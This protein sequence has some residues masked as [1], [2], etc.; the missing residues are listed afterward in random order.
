MGKGFFDAPVSGGGGFFTGGTDQGFFGGPG[1]GA[2]S[3]PKKKSWKDFGKDIG[4][5]GSPLGYFLEQS[6]ILPGPGRVIQALGS[7]PIEAVAHP[8]ALTKGAWQSV[9]GTVESPY[10]IY[11]LHHTGM[12][13]GDVGDAVIK[14]FVSDY[15]RRYGKN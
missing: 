11:Q 1:V 14:S 10:A 8:K 6:G 4:F 9:V 13:W 5:Y 15:K 7:A 2:P 12:G 3:K